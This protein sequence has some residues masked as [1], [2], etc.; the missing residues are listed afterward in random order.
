MNFNELFETTTAKFKH[1]GVENPEV[2]TRRLIENHFNL[3]LSQQILSGYKEIAQELLISFNKLVTRRQNREPLQYI[4][5]E[6]EFW[7]MNFL[8]SE[9][10]L[11]PR[12]ETEFLLYHTLK[13]LKN[14]YHGGA[15]LDMCTGSGVIAT[16]LASEL[17]NS[18]VVATDKSIKALNIAQKNTS[19]KLGN[20]RVK[21][22]CSDLFNGLNQAIQYEVI[23]SNPPY[24]ADHDIPQLQPEVRDWEPKMALK[25]GSVGMDIIREIHTNIHL[26]LQPKGWIFLEIGSDQGC[27]V[28][29]LF[30]ESNKDNPQFL[31]IDIIHDWSGRD[32]VFQAQ[33]AG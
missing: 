24:I 17:K 15:I 1:V 31:N 4:L 19:E 10:V 26:Y 8:V 5:Q 6:C 23:V 18:Q 30:S 3:S 32:R 33:L 7:S 20:N 25:A 21:L 2:D 13:V 28:S 27:E 9:D 14:N 29:R 12:Q 16:I 22:I 11:I